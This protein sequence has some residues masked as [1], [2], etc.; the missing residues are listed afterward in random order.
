VDPLSNQI[1]HITRELPL[2]ASVHTVVSFLLFFIRSSRVI[3]TG[4][5]HR[6]LTD[7]HSQSLA[8]VLARHSPRPSVEDNDICET[9]KDAPDG[10]AVCKEVA[11]PR[12]H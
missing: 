9:E 3:Y 4:K 1:R 8:R 10:K 5:E 12:A 2:L 11:A 7:S 6:I